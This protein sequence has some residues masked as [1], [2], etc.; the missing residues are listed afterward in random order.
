MPE[1][2][3]RPFRLG[4]RVRPRRPILRFR[5]AGY[6]TWAV[7]SINSYRLADAFVVGKKEQKVRRK[8]VRNNST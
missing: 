6:C 5:T 4:R 8:I 1:D 3:T 2:P 7:V